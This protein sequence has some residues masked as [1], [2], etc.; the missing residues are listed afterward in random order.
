MRI[1][2]K[3]RTDYTVTDQ[4]TASSQKDKKIQEKLA[5]QK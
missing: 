1:L 5:G 4:Y 2:V 3:V